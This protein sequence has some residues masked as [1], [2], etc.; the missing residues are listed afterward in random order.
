MC[1]PLTMQTSTRQVFKPHAPDVVGIIVR[2]PLLGR[3][4]TSNRRLPIGN[5][6]TGNFQTGNFQ[7]GNSQAEASQSRAPDIT[8]VIAME[9]MRGDL[10]VVLIYG[11][12]HRFKCIYNGICI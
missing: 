12:T 3:T 9:G 11:P 10:Q 2:E 5:F 1:R 6:Q 8:E 7:T 4:E